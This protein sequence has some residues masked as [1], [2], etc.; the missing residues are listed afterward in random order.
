MLRP[1]LQP[2]H[3]T[4]SLS[5]QSHLSYRCVS[6]KHFPLYPLYGGYCEILHFRMGTHSKIVGAWRGPQKPTLKI[7]MLFVSKN[8]Q[9]DRHSWYFSHPSNEGIEA[10]RAVN[11]KRMTNLGLLTPTLMLSSL[12]RQIRAEWLPIQLL[13]AP[14]HTTQ[15]HFPG[16]LSLG[17][18][19]ISEFWTMD[20]RQKW[21][22]QFQSCPLVLKYHLCA[23]SLLSSPPWVT[24]AVLCWRW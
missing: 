3:R 15:L 19:L 14:G 10:W 5:A 12:G 23:V 9:W 2:H 17:W 4:A 7:L 13:S 24:L 21:C 16:H 20:Y 18:S 1:Q 22:C 11:T 6:H 8:T